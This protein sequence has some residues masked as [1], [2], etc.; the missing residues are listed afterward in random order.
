MVRWRYFLF[1]F[2][3]TLGHTLI[4]ILDFV[5]VLNLPFLL[6]FFF[7]FEIIW[8]INWN[9]WN[10]LFIFLKFYLKIK[11][12]ISAWPREILIYRLERLTFRLVHRVFVFIS[13]CEYGVRI[14][15]L[16]CLFAIF[17]GNYCL[18][19]LLV[20]HLLYLVTT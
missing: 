15:F 1:F 14:L 5:A 17:V 10:F 7:L 6:R 3:V 20:T 2:V 9:L 8:K 13:K 4:W 11:S 12:G 16:I 18:S 19:V